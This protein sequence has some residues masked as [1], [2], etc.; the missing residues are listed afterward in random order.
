MRLE[1]ALIKAGLVC[2]VRQGRQE[3]VADF[4]RSHGEALMAGPEVG[5]GRGR[6]R[7]CCECRRCGRGCGVRLHPHALA[8]QR[9]G[10]EATAAAGSPAGGFR[11]QLTC[12]IAAPPSPARPQACVWRQWAALALLPAPRRDPTFAPYFSPEWMSLLEVRAGGG[13]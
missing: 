3:R 8:G 12:G 7:P 13:G 4:F 2:C 6:A 9:G 1:V 5:R 10:D 11:P